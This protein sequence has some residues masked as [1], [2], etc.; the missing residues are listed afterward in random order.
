MDKVIKIFKQIQKT[1]SLNDKK[2]IIIENKEN[3]LF[4]MCLKFLLDRNIVTGI[5]SKKIKKKVAPSSELAPYYLSIHSTFEDVM[6]YL[7]RI[8]LG[9]M[10]IS[11]KFKHF[12]LDMKVIGNFMNR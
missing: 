8:I 7:K 6:N 1:S 12:Y 10:K 4:K 11:M 5:S 3:E 9:K 2:A